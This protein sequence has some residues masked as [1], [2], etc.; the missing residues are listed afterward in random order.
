MAWMA[1]LAYDG[2]MTRPEPKQPTR[3]PS[4]VPGGTAPSWIGLPRRDPTKEGP[5]MAAARAMWNVVL[6]LLLGAAVGGF[7]SQ[8]VGEAATAMFGEFTGFWRMV[9]AIGGWAAGAFTAFVCF[10]SYYL[11]ASEG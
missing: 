4:S 7:G 5:I 10:M 8:L 3:R 11:D 6:S 2:G 1:K 9:I